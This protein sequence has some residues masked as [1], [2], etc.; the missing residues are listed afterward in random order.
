MYPY[1]RRN[2][3]KGAAV[4]DKSLLPFLT[5]KKSGDVYEFICCYNAYPKAAPC[6]H[7]SAFRWMNWRL[8]MDQKIKIWQLFDLGKDPQENLD[9]MKNKIQARVLLCS[10]NGYGHKEAQKE[11]RRQTGRSSCI[12]RLFVAILT[13]FGGKEREE[14]RAGCIRVVQGDPFRLSGC[15]DTG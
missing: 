13:L 4:A 5:G 10:R 3:M 8:A 12:L 11:Q 15:P 2:F 6:R 1:M 7:L 14:G 9:T